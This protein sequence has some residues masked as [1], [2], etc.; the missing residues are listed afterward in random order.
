MKPVKIQTT[1]L[2]FVEETIILSIDNC[3]QH[4]HLVNR[5]VCKPL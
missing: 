3:G 5:V 2:I 1:I 4:L